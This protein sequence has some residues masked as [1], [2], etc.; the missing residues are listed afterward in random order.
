[1]SRLQI[2]KNTEKFFEH[3]LTRNKDMGTMRKSIREKRLCLFAIGRDNGIYSRYPCFGKKQ[4]LFSLMLSASLPI[5]LLHVNNI[6]KKIF[7]IFLCSKP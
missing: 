7:V 6:R 1:V 4:G 5:S 3:I 2:E